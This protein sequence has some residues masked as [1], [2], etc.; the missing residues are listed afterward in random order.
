MYNIADTLQDVPHYT[1]HRKSFVWIEI[2]D[3]KG[4]EVQ[5]LVTK[6]G[7]CDDITVFEDKYTFY[8]LTMNTSIPYVGMEM[9]EKFDKEEESSRDVFLQEY[10]C[11]E[12]LGDLGDLDEIEIIEKL[13]HYF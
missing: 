11:D 12:V 1:I 8:V 9:F 6:A 5:S 7:T 4:A 10:E 3:N 13:L 2:T